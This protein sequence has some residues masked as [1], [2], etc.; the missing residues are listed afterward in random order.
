LLRS[1]AMGKPALRVTVLAWAEADARALAARLV[2]PYL[3]LSACALM[4]RP[5]ALAEQAPQ[6]VVLAVGPG[7]AVD[8][9]RQANGLAP[10]LPLL[11]AGEVPWPPVWLAAFSTGVVAAVPLAKLEAAALKGL[12]ASLAG[13]PGALRGSGTYGE[14]PAFLDAL[15]VLGRTGTLV[16][17]SVSAG[18]GHGELLRGQH[19][20]ARF[21]HL[22]GPD[23]WRAL[24]EARASWLFREHPP[25][26]APG[27]QAELEPACAQVLL[28]QEASAA[29]AERAQHLGR[30]GFQVTTAHDAEAAAAALARGAFDAALLATAG[31]GAL[32][33]RLAEEARA[34]ETRLLCVSDPDDRFDEGLAR[35]AAPAEVEAVLRAALAPRCEALARLR[36][37]TL[38]EALG[39][40]VD[41]L[42]LQ[43]LLRQLAA[44][45]VTGTL[46]LQAGRAA[47]RAWFVDGRLC[48]AR[49]ED[50]PVGRQGV[51]ALAPV[52][53]QRGLVATLEVAGLPEGEGFGGASTH[54]VLR[55]VAAR[56]GATA[57]P[58]S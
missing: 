47:T 11:V 12:E 13:R 32:Q 30:V 44:E 8:A 37:W 16:V 5:E 46:E 33:Q 40:E 2:A 50:G 51:D 25:L 43:W 9:V 14:L 7:E 22:T 4:V 41:S 55:A 38:D 26:A 15:E 52:L 18:V 57:R 53:A 35:D 31:A 17:T 21:G 24:R 48:Q 49:G 3:E 10:G 42:G 58:Q 54:E 28:V 36:A 27:V 29:L 23:A 56:T 39:F 34:R 45:G 19:G 20:E 1:Q 6:L